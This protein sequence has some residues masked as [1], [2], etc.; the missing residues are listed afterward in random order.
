MMVKEWYWKVFVLCLA[1]ATPPVMVC[2]DWK[3]VP[4]SEF[5]KVKQLSDEKYTEL[6]GF[7]MD[8]GLASYR[9][10]VDAAPFDR[11]T[12]RVIRNGSQFRSEIADIITV[13]GGGM[14]VVLDK[15]ERS[16]FATDPVD[17]NEP[18]LITSVDIVLGSIAS[19]S[20]RAVPDGI[21]YKLVYREGAVYGYSVVR[22]DKQGWLRGT[23]TI[24]AREVAEDPSLPLSAR[25]R[26]RLDVTYGIP[27][28]FEGAKSKLTDPWSFV[29]ELHNGLVAVGE[30][31]GASVIDARYK[32]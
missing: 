21:E 23:S 14:R 19:S 24:W 17:F 15:E 28:R 6:A 30:W 32:P 2:Q 4:V 8:I 12:A 5:V 13:Q 29:Q 16:I 11:S 3:P 9:S 7:S 18:W 25:Y 20:T 27:A 1:G 22:Y 31:K 26:P 10:F